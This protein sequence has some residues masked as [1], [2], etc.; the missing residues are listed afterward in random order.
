MISLTEHQGQTWLASLST[1]PVPIAKR[2]LLE[3]AFCEDPFPELGK[4]IMRCEVLLKERDGKNTDIKVL[5]MSRL[6][7]LA[8]AL[9]VRTE[10]AE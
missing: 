8:N 4:I 7:E 3:A 2:A 9:Q 5:P 10:E 1:Y 6:V